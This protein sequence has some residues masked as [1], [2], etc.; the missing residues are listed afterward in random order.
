MNNDSEY[1]TEAN[2]F[3]SPTVATAA[4][5]P[6]E[7]THLQQYS[8]VRT[9]LQLTYYSIAAIAVA[10]ILVVAVSVFNFNGQAELGTMFFGTMALFT[11]IVFVA[12]AASLVGFC[13]CAASPH[14]KERQLA[15]ISIAGFICYIAASIASAVMEG[16]GF[17]GMV[18]ILSLAGTIA[19]VVSTITFCLLLKRIGKNIS[20]PKMA[21]AAHSAM[22]WYISLLAIGIIGDHCDIPRRGTDTRDLLRRRGRTANSVRH[23][24]GSARFGN[25][26][27]IPGD[28]ANRN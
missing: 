15:F 25:A 6:S 4:N 11:L 23:R 14:P 7:K 5:I 27:S 10:L 20:K 18:Q 2:P 12:G 26:V 3:A 21:K 13:M 1:E 17:P 28:A 16:G 24:H 19:N 22:L 8:T 9:G